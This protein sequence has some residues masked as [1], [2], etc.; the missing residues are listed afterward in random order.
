[1]VEE[2]SIEGRVARHEVTVTPADPTSEIFILTRPRKGRSSRDFHSKLPPERLLTFR[3][4]QAVLFQMLA[5]RFRR[6]GVLSKECE[7]LLV[8]WTG[9]PEGELDE[10]LDQ[11]V[12]L[13][14]ATEEERDVAKAVGLRRLILLTQE[15]ESS[16]S[17][18]YTSDLR[19][20]SQLGAPV[21]P[22]LRLKSF[23]RT[24]RDL[25]PKAMGWALHG[26]RFANRYRMHLTIPP[27]FYAGSV[28]LWSPPTFSG[29]KTELVE[30]RGVRIGSHDKETNYERYIGIQ[31]S[32]TKQSIRIAANGDWRSS[33][34]KPHVLVRF[35][36]VP[37]GGSASAASLALVTLFLLWLLAVLGKDSSDIDWAALLMAVPST[38]AVVLLTSG[39]RADPLEP[40][41]PRLFNYVSLVLSLLAIS[42]HL[43]LSSCSA[44]LQSGPCQFRP[45]VWRLQRNYL[46][47]RGRP[48]VDPACLCDHQRIGRRRLLARRGHALSPVA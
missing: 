34:H 41:S 39:T 31:V 26:V 33:G 10:L 6:G 42:V 45:T 4:A 18:T 8:S 44:D 40:T 21:H 29:P 19:S 38:H 22:W 37:P 17:F 13:T 47:R 15:G 11:L 36:Q 2:I 12:A 30:G 16:A 3:Q 1:M 28:D 32:P 9:K 27:G 35:S 46:V 25:P 5:N 43:T 48:M 23:A 20:A 24:S 7:A 14:S